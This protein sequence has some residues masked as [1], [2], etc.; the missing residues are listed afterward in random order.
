MWSIYIRIPFIIHKLCGLLSKRDAK[1]DKITQAIE[2]ISNSI[3]QTI[4]KTSFQ[5]DEKLALM[6]QKIEK[7]SSVVM[8]E[9]ATFGPYG[10]VKL[11]G[12]S[13]NVTGPFRKIVVKT[14]KWLDSYEAYFSSGNDR[15]V[16][17]LR[18]ESVDGDVS[19]FGM[20]ISSYTSGYGF[21]LGGS[22][23]R[24]NTYFEKI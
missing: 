17:G 3:R 11:I 14:K 8:N 18:F 19:E 9:T 13:W 2:N 5:R 21:G 20:N 22:T 12:S 24:K 1:L 10:K 23:G 7:I 4:E 16:Q 15:I 6:T